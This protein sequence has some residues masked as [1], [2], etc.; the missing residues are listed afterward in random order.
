MDKKQL[1]EQEIRTRYIIPA[2]Q[3]AGWKPS[4]IRE[5]YQLTNGRIIA[6]G[7]STKRERPKRPDFVLFYKPHLPLAVIEA[8][9]NNH[10][11]SDGVQQALG[12]A[13]SLLVPFVFTSNGDGF[14][15]HNR[16]VKDG[17]KECILQLSEFPSPETLWQMYKQNAGIDEQQEKIVM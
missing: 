10:A 1:T 9:D 16:F 13:Q 12:Y 17:A 7:G 4:Q 14:T 8:K 11:M 3:N 15:F 5:E 6:R 2:F